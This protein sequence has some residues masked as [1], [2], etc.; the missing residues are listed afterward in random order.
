MKKFII[1]NLGNDNKC[2]NS[3]DST[4]VISNGS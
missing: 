2:S 1:Q 3:R 4:V